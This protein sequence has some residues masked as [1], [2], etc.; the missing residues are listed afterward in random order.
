MKRLL[1]SIVAVTAMATIAQAAEKTV[2]WDKSTL[3]RVG[4]GSY[5]R[6]IR[7]KGGDIL[8]GHECGGK[9]CISRSK[10]DGRTWTEPAVVASAPQGHAANSELL[11][12][13]NGHI[14]YMY[15]ERPNDGVHRFTIQVAVSKDNGNTWKHLSKVYEADTEFHNGCW[16]PAAIQLPSGEVQLFFANENPYRNSTEQEI[17]LCR[18]F[19]N[20]KSWTKAEA[21]SFRAGHRD[22]MP[23]P[24]IL[25]DGKGIVVAIEDNGYTLM[26][27]PTIVWTSMEDNWRKCATAASPNRW[28]A[29]KKPTNVE[30]GGAPYIRQMP[31]GETV[32]SFQSSVGRDQV[33]MVVYVGDENARNFTGRSVP[34]E[35]PSKVGGWWNS[36][37]V[38]NDKTIT[39]VSSYEGS[40]WAIDGHVEAIKQPISGSGSGL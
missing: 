10:D 7:I 31:T 27:T 33:Q 34:F 35:L 19:N 12:L 3:A 13:A 36:L 5:A 9:V 23:S 15:N 26:F 38:K 40:V 39:A 16:E 1:G 24:L 20:G 25:K 4:P 21:I 17:S 2:V 30:W 28:S 29:I 32:L 37:F 8:C 6:M 22:G 11:E 14:L 18:S